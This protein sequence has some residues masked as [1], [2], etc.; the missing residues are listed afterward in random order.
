MATKKPANYD[1]SSIKNLAGRD[2][3]RAKPQMYIGAT[4]S[5]GVF[6]ILRETADNIIDEAISGHCTEGEVYISDD[7]SYW[8]LDNGRGIPVGTIKVKDAVTS[9]SHNVPALQAITSLLHTGGKMETSGDSAYSASRGCF[10]GETKVRLLDGSVKTMKQLFDRWQ[11]NKD[12]I[13]VMTFD[14]KAQKVVPSFISHVQLTMKTR[15]LVEVVLDTGDSVRVT[16]DHPFYVN[17]SGEIRRVQAG[18]LLAGDSLV[19]TYYSEDKDGYLVQTEQGRKFKVHR[20][21]AEFFSEFPLEKDLHEVHHKSRNVKNNTPS[22]L[23]VKTKSD[24]QR[25]HSAERSAYSYCKVMEDLG[26]D[27]AD[28]MGFVRSYNHQVVSVTRISTPEPIP[29]YDITVDNEHTFFIEPGVLVKNTHGVG[30][31]ATNFLSLHFRVRTFYK[32][33]WWQI[34][35]KKGELV[36]EVST[37]AAPTHPFSGEKVTKGTVLDF[38]PDPS[39]F[40]ELKFST[41][42]LQEWASLASYFTP[43]FTFTISHHSGKSK[44][45]HAEDGPLQYVKDVMSKLEVTPISESTFSF[46][47]PLLDCV[48]QY[49][50]LDGNSMRGFTNGLSNAEGGVHLDA[51]FASLKTAIQPYAKKNQVFTVNELR[52]GLVGLVNVKLSAP[53]FDSQTKEKLVDPRGR[54]PVQEHLDVALAEFFKKNKKFALELCDRCTQLKQLRNRFQQ[55]RRALSEIRKIVS[56]GLPSKAA[57]APGCPPE[58]RELILLEG[59]SAGGT[60]RAARDKSFQEILPLKGKIK[61]AMRDKKNEALESEEV[62]N[63]LAMIGFNPKAEDPLSNLRVGK[64]IH[65]ADPDPDGYHINA[66]LLTLEQ[67]YLPELFERGMIYIANVPEYYALD[68]KTKKLYTGASASEVASKLEENRLKLPIKHIK[69]YGEVS[70]EVLRY[71]AFDPATRS[72]SR[73]LPSTA[74]GADEAFVKLMSN[75]SESRKQLL[76][77]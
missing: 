42:L 72:L 63:I 61:N 44:T 52:E 48:F 21:V 31:K 33:K 75:D 29:V 15:D 38:K 25:E 66:L 30:I 12:P 2:A 23:E 47:N 11:K 50:T 65:M 54:G 64:I 77:I 70:A 28:L 58:K 9:S 20:R 1:E 59:E 74:S 14:L 41:T 34:A 57:L 53:Q 3:V 19:S 36:T 46:S 69:G 27:T 56:K 5:R 22:N 40:S 51:F 62:L 68:V 7:G 17:D 24:H 6:T 73:V 8:V 60:G 76:G 18:D 45:Y 10:A 16:P 35:Y 67:K 49:S 4:D 37:C 32:G 71:L 13:P 43:G 39:I 26:G 55:S